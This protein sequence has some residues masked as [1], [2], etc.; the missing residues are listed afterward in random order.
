MI[1]NHLASSIYLLSEYVL[2]AP[3]STW[4]EDIYV[5]MLSLH[6]DA[7]FIDMTPHFSSKEQYEPLSIEKL[8]RHKT[9][10]F[11]YVQEISQLKLVW[12]ILNGVNATEML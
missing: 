3:F 2:W 1:T 6:L 11:V 7:H 5:A 4:L 12:N 9:I 8:V 10:S